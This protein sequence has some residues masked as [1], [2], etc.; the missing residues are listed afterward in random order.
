MKSSK[1]LNIQTDPSLPK[2]MQNILNNIGILDNYNRSLT[3]IDEI[4]YS[5]KI[6]RSDIPEEYTTT[7]EISTETFDSPVTETL[8]NLFLVKK[9]KQRIVLFKSQKI[10]Q[11]HLFFSIRLVLLYAEDFALTSI[12]FT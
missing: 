2:T 3:K 10:R 11:F 9:L 4:P 6:R 12:I 1:S 8:G 7:E 5:K